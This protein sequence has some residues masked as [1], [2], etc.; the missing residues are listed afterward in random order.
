M[1]RPEKRA[2]DRVDVKF[3]VRVTCPGGSVIEGVV[4]NL[5]ALG[6][7]ISTTDL[8]TPLD[9]GDLVELAIA[10]PAEGKPPGPVVVGGEVLRLEQE[11]AGGEIRRSFAVRFDTP[12]AH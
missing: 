4:D 1:T 5:G 3:T 10:M 8:E 6:A 2:H 9:T 7:F 12:I 11:F